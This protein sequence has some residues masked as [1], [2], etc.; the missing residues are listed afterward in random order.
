[1]KPEGVTYQLL[2]EFTNDFSEEKKL[3]EG[4][5]GVVYKVI[6]TQFLSHASYPHQRHIIIHQAP[7]FYD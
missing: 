4:A 1:M 7:I 5:F 2:R 3:G 6:I